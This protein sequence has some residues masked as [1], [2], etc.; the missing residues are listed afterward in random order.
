MTGT[1][2]FKIDGGSPLYGKVQ[3]SGAKNAALPIMAASILADGPI[4]LHRVPRLRDVATLRQVLNNVGVCSRFD[5]SETI[6]LQTI[7]NKKTRA[8]Y[9]HV[10]RMRASFCVLGP[11]L[12]QRGQATVAMPGGC[13][14]GQRPVDLHLKGLEALGAQIRIQ[15]GNVIARCPQLRGTDVDLLGPRGSSVTATANIL[16]AAT[17]ARGRT[18][19]RG[20]AREPEIVDLGRFLLSLGAEIRGLGTSTV[21]IIGVEGLAQRD[22]RHDS[23]YPVISDRIEAATLM[24]A[25]A[26]CGGRVAIRGCNVDHLQSEVATL[27]NSGMTIRTQVDELEIDARQPARSFDIAARPY[28]G[29]PTD[30]QP[31]FTALAA[32]AR[33]NSEICDAVF[34]D[35]WLH[36]AELARLGARIDRSGSAAYVSGIPRGLSGAP[37]IARDLRG[38]AALVLAGLA[39]RGRTVV[40]GIHHIDRG[41]VE[42]EVKLASLGA[43]IRRCRVNRE[44]PTD[45][46]RFAVAADSYSM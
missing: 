13:N 35:R 28:P 32:C 26:I 14:L 44:S 29:I 37:V 19:I 23:G 21:E 25:T 39:A 46:D 33:G 18:V 40:G 24:I 41:Y 42:L 2:V 45:R 17:L 6:V 8:G 9:R 1:S 34:P 31:L 36:V 7:D 15:Q 5:D 38:G 11:L 20:A 3:V 27:V 22:V 12:A 30:V 10:S 4:R 16:A 43:S